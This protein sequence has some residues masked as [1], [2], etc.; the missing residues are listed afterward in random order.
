MVSRRRV[1]AT[2]AVAVGFAGCSGRGGGTGTAGTAL[3]PTPGPG[4][5]D[6][7]DRTA[8]ETATPTA[9]TT[10]TSYHPGPFVLWNRDHRTHELRLSVHGPD[11]TTV[12][13][14]SWTL[15]PDESRDVEVERVPVGAYRFVARVDGH[16]ATHEYAVD[17]CAPDEYFQLLVE[18]DGRPRFR[19]LRETVDPPR[20]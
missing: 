15:E 2:I 1:L 14:G 3:D 17:E 8:S 4:T 5:S 18:A 16:E 9:T 19:R 13:E 6:A 12:F 11:G 10:P 20:C 7:G